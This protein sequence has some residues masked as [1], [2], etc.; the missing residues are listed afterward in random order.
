[1]AAAAAI[2]AAAAVALAA[3]RRLLTPHPPPAP[4]LSVRAVPH[5]GPPRL[6]SVHITA[7]GAAHTVRVEPSSGTS[8][9]TIEEVRP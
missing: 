5:T 6:V 3:R 2:L 1:V 4:G 9:M 8:T 7:A